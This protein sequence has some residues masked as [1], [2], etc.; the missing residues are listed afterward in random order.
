MTAL[1]KNVY[2][3]FLRISRSRQNKPFKL[4]KDFSEFD[5]TDNVCIQ[6]LELF[7]NRF[8]HIDLDDFFKAPFEVYLDNKS[9]DLKFYTTQRALKVYTLYM[10][11][12]ADKSPDCDDQLYSIKSSLK[13]ISSWCNTNNIH[14]GAYIEHMTNNTN[15]FL[16]HLKQHKVNIY[17][18]FAFENF[19][20]VIS[21]I[22]IEYLRFIL[23]SYADNIS[24][25]R[26]R[27]IKSTSAKTLSRKGLEIISNKFNT[28]KK[29]DLQ[30]S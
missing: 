3:T 13:Y 5:E 4:R 11:R 16:L 8:K 24:I 25:F 15:T 14:P 20:D 29:V 1:E 10:Q 17:T 22:D 12:Q 7:F 30:Q 6:K 26:T 9:F 23:G 27:F 18:L 21:S 28:N 19:D 2:N